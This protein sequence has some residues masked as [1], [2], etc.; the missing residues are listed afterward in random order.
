M[1]Y[2]FRKAGIAARQAQLTGTISFER[3]APVYLPGGVSP[4]SGGPAGSNLWPL[5]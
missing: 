1:T 3:K 4:V 2:R 5:L